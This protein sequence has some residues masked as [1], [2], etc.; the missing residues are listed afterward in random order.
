ARGSRRHVGGT[1]GTVL[2]PGRGG[3]AS[4]A[5]NAGMAGL[6]GWASGPAGAGPHG[7]L[8]Q[9][10]LGGG[11]MGASRRHPVRGRDQTHAWGNG[12]V[13]PDQTGAARLDS[14]RVFRCLRCRCTEV[15]PGRLVRAEVLGAS[16]AGP[17]ADGAL[18][19]G[20]GTALRPLGGALAVV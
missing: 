15:R 4:G 16:I 8:A 17:A 20:A 12:A 6:A 10:A 1:S 2:D 14:L 19:R 5:G 3:F 13:P 7:L 11:P 18:E 9:G